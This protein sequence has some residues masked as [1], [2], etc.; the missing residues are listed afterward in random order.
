MSLDAGA[1]LADAARDPAYPTVSPVDRL[2]PCHCRA[3]LA[4]PGGVITLEGVLGA[5][6]RGHVS[7]WPAASDCENR[8]AIG[9]VMVSRRQEPW[10]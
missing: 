6:R 1:L 2:Y 9:Y 3:P 7:E 5:V 10:R 4:S 8:S